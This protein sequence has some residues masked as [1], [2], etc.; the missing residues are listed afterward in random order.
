MRIYLIGFMGAGKSTL[1]P[2]LAKELGYSCIE[3]DNLVERLAGKTIPDIFNI[4][5][6]NYFRELEKQVLHFTQ[7]CEDTII[8]TGGG[9]PCYADNME[10]MKQHGLTVYLSCDDEVLIQ[11]IA[12][13]Q[14]GRP[15]FTDTHSVFKLLHSRIVDYQ[16]ADMQFSNNDSRE[17]TL[18]TIV[19]ALKNTTVY[20]PKD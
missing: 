15:L 13:N 14:K 18:K 5:G 3:T 1:G 2:L 11:R 8:C 12:S 4:H 9:T 17:I 16:K 19:E 6:E 10:W 7:L 20:R